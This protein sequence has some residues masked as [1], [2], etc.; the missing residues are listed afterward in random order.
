MALE[1]VEGAVYIFSHIQ[2][3]DFPSLPAMLLPASCMDIQRA[4]FNITMYTTQT[5]I[6]NSFYNRK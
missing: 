2:P 3:I 6:S 5:C 4:E 1:I